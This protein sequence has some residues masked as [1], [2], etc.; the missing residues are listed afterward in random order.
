ML[1]ELYA[2]LWLSAGYTT[3]L[4]AVRREDELIPMAGTISLGLWGVLAV[5]ETV[6]KYHQDGTSTDITIGTL[7]YVPTAMAVLTLG[8]LI[9][10]YFGWYPP[11]PED[12]MTEED[13]A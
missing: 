3:H 10:W 7:Q 8:A 2:L 1:L 4:W 5:T 9:G 11:Q 6:T 13:L 12:A